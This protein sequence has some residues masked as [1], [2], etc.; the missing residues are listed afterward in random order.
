MALKRAKFFTYGIDTMCAEIRKF[1]EDGGVILE[2][3]DLEKEPLNYNEL[4]KMIGHINFD[5]FINKNSKSKS[6]SKIETN[7]ISREE[8]L[9]LIS[10][11]NSLLKQ[12]II[13]TARLTVV[14]CDKKKIKEMLQLTFNGSE[15]VAQE[16]IGNVTNHRHSRSGKNHAVSG[17]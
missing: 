5:H 17:K 14:G 10:E 3:R 7:N 1:I 2:Q 12:P 9:S 13:K 4:N 15:G 8:V 16:S 11:D 6:L